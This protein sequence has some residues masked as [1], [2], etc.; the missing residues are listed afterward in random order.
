MLDE[1][2][3]AS[4]EVSVSKSRSDELQGHKEGTTTGRDDTYIS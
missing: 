1:R 3:R 4:E 2:K